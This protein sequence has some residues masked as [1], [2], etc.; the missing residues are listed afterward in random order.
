MRKLLG[1]LF[2]T[3]LGLAAIAG[4]AKLNLYLFPW[5]DF[6]AALAIE[7]RGE[8]DYWQAWLHALEALVAQRRLAAPERVEEIAALWQ[9]AA[10]RTPHG[11]AILLG[12]A[13]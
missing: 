13:G 2:G 8:E 9:R 1:V 12:N 11:E 4:M 3:A 6:A 10:E 5:P 7:L